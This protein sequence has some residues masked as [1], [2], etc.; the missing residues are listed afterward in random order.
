MLSFIY[1]YNTL[2]ELGKYYCF[3]GKL[4]L[5]YSNTFQ[6][7]EKNY[8]LFRN[9]ICRLSELFHQGIEMVL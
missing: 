9:K 5:H 1:V 7:L 2:L 4:V 6:C 3:L 8:A